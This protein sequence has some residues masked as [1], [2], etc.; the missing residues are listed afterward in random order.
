MAIV[1]PKCN[2]ERQPTESGPDH[3]CP[4]C[5]IVYAKFDPE[6]HQRNQ[7]LYEK[8]RARNHA[9]A[10]GDWSAIPK[11]EIPADVHRKLTAQLILTTTHT[12]PGR[13]IGKVIDVISAECAYG[14]NIFR[15]VFAGI[16][17]LTGGRSGGTQNVLRDAKNAVMTQLKMEAYAIG[18]QAVIGVDLD[19]SEISGG[20]KS[21]LFVVATGTAVTL[22]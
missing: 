5:G 9:M 17:D 12:V 3:S 8:T 22:V 19:Y 14:M 11:E 15:D 18:A 4:A 20:G 10:T 21:M 2:H 7:A 13:E 16:T 6:T 1:C